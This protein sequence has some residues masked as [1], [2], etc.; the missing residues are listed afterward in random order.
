MMKRKRTNIKRPSEKRKPQGK[1]TRPRT[2]WIWNFFKEVDD[3]SSR[4][5]CQ[6]EG[7]GKIFTWCSSSSLMKT[8]LLGIYHITKGNA[9]S[10]LE[11]LQIGDQQLIDNIVEEENAKTN[12]YSKQEALTKNV[13]GFVIGTVQPLSKDVICNYF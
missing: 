6:I 1:I 3:D 11:A 4:L 5:I 10:Y 12:P 13:I 8:H 2:S 9:A 7:C